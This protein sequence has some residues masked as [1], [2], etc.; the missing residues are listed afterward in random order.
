M[1]VLPYD[2]DTNYVLWCYLAYNDCNYFRDNAN[3]VHVNVDLGNQYD[4]TVAQILADLAMN[5]HLTVDDRIRF[6]RMDPKNHAFKFLSYCK[7][8]TL[9]WRLI[10]E[11]PGAET[12]AAAWFAHHDMIPFL[13]TE[14]LGLLLPHVTEWW[15]DILMGEINRRGLIGLLED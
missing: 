4:K 5:R 6:I 10:D 1:A 3:A 11:V 2:R 12:E 7:D 9:A 13:T 15:G 14:Q 8:A